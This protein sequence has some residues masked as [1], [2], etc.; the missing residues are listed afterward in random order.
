MTARAKVEVSKRI[1]AL[2][3][4][5]PEQQKVTGPLVAYLVSIGWKLEQMVFGKKE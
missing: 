5:I 2:L 4:D 1:S 3:K